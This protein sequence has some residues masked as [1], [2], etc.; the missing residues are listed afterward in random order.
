M[1][2]D[3]IARF[4]LV[5]HRRGAPYKHELALIKANRHENKAVAELP[6]ATATSVASVVSRDEEEEEE[7]EEAGEISR[8]LALTYQPT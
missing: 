7:E 1:P 4:S 6:V 5:R 8:S 2:P 3:A